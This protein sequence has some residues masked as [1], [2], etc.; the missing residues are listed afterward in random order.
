MYPN[1][2]RIITQ[3]LHT[4]VSAFTP[5]ITLILTE[6]LPFLVVWHLVMRYW[7][8]NC[9]NRAVSVNIGEMRICYNRICVIT[10][11][12]D[13]FIQILQWINQKI[14][15]TDQ[16]YNWCCVCCRNEIGLCKSMIIISIVIG[17][18]NPLTAAS[19]F[20]RCRFSKGRSFESLSIDYYVNMNPS[21]HIR[22]MACS[23]V[24]RRQQPVTR[25][26]CSF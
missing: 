24:P 8:I 20:H 14:H 22:Y 18:I 15:K 7:S 10:W 1:T 5:W 13:P 11:L 16:Y 2:N 19:I 4:P 23:L 12:N 25:A 3:A 21:N 9:G 17:N 6:Q 26:R